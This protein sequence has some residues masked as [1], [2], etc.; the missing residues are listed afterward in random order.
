MNQ[1]VFVVILFCFGNVAAYPSGA[2]S[3]ACESM[4]PNHGASAQPNNESPYNVTISSSAYTYESE[5][6]IQISSDVNFKGFLLQVRNPDTDEIYGEFIENP[7]STKYLGCTGGTSNAVTHSDSTNKMFLEFTWKANFQ[8][9]PSTLV[10]YVTV[11]Q[12]RLTFWVK[13]EGPEINSCNLNCLNGGTCSFNG[14][15]EEICNCDDGFS[16]PTCKI[17]TVYCPCKN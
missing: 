9:G 12:S 2:A 3:S 8:N 17:I 5:I 16:G 7:P 15:G 4:T 10:P 6:Q 13:L 11:V 1:V 14:N